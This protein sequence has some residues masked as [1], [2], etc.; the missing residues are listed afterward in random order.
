MIE[1]VLMVTVARSYHIS[2]INNWF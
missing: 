1:F 2:A